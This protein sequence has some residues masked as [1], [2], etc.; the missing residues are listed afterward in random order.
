MRRI[1]TA[2]ALLLSLAA[3]KDDSSPAPSASAPPTS[4]T[5]SP[6]VPVVPG[7]GSKFAQALAEKWKEPLTAAEVERYL[8]LAPDFVNATDVAG[9]TAAAAAHG[10]TVAE[11]SRIAARVNS[12]YA[13]LQAKE[14]GLTLPRGLPPESVETVRPY[15][16]RI[17]A[18]S[19]KSK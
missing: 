1:A 16:D 7:P 18:A 4:S 13:G 17:R 11:A 14:H 6:A 15:A 9:M 19:K 2:L 8:A 12:A 5:A 10:M 3:C